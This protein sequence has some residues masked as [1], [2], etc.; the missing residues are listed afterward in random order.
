[1]TLAIIA[2]VLGLAV[3]AWSADKFVIG[4]SSVARYLGM[5][6]LLIGMLVIGFGTSAPE[7]VVSTFASLDGNPELAI[8]NALGSNIVNVGLILGITAIVVP[9]MVHRGILRKEL[10]VL[11]AATAVAWLLM[12]DGTMSTPDAAILLVLLVVLV[13]WSI[14]SAKAN[15]DDRLAADAA[16][17]TAAAGLSKRAAWTWLAVGLVLLVVS[18][19]ALVWGAVQIAQSLGWSDLVIGL[20][21]VAVGTS[22]PELAAS[23]A[24]ARKGETDLALGNVIGSNLF[25]TLGVIGIAGVITPINVDHAVLTRDMPMVAIMTVLLAVFAW[26]RLG[27]GRVNRVEGIVLLVVW[28][29]Y[30]TLLLATAG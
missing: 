21:V 14:V 2:T 5:A 4:A 23:L 28:V 9:V 11:L 3:L 12:L 27:Q 25:N 22:A 15:K 1:M 19:R 30:T 16:A 18:S 6:P 13:A 26:G 29:G 7:M 20:T 8:G 10:P 17:E 24:A